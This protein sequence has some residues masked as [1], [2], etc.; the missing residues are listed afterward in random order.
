M[1]RVNDLTAKILIDDGSEVNY[2]DK[3][4][5]QRNDI[6]IEGANYTATI[7]NEIPQE[8]KVIAQKLQLSMGG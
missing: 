3:D 5:F 8:T 7:D 6:A 2:I 1:G 4:F